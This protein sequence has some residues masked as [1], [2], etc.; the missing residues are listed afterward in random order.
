MGA[1]ADSSAHIHLTVNLKKALAVLAMFVA[2]CATPCVAQIF[3]SNQSPA[4]ITDDIWCVTYA[5]GT[6]A[7][8]TNQG[9]LLTST[10]GLNWSSQTIEAGTLLT[11]IA[12]GNGTWI[13]VGAGGAIL[14]SSDLKTWVSA[15][16]PTTNQLNGVLYSGSEIGRSDFP[17]DNVP[18]HTS[19]WL[20]VGDDTIVTS[21]DA[22][23]WSVQTSSVTGYL[24]GISTI[25]VNNN[26]NDTGVSSETGISFLVSGDDGSDSGV[27]LINLPF[28]SLVPNFVLAGSIPSSA[29]NLEA[30]LNAQNGVVVA[31]GW[32]GT[33][34]YS[35]SGGPLSTSGPG[36]SQVPPQLGTWN[37]SPTVTP[38]VTFRGLTYGNGYWVTAGDGG[39]IFTSTDGINW[40]QRFAGDSPSTLSTSTLL[41]AA[42]SESLQ[43]FVVTGTGGTILV[44]NSPPTVF[45]NVSTRG[46]VSNAETLI[47]GFVIEGT[48][49]RT[50]LIRADGPILDTFSVPNPLPD[51]VLTV[52]NNSGTVIATN[53]GWT[54][55]TNHA[56]ISTAALEVGAFALPN[57]SP[58]SALLL[59]LQ[60]GAYT[61]Q[62]TSAGGN[63]GIALFEAYTN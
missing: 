51:P 24:R 14:V 15:R 30:I 44:S 32:G 49:P 22:I 34:L 7:A 46:Y 48:A 31:V 62:I 45:G 23:N 27:V 63:S 4:G 59:T 11:S 55:N 12:Y 21:Q 2:A 41:S 9:N 16:S 35:L 57:L 56:S 13:A 37:S 26:L 18:H 42:Y 58:D 25:T 28:F 60:P 39:N 10:N 50:V 47:G 36:G 43:R 20:A 29:Q 40:T 1:T 5:N 33:I 53:A 6:F 3:W 19:T 54:T 61:A 8:V 38:N 17:P 52:Y